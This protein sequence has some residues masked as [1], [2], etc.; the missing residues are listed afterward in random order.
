MDTRIAVVSIIVYDKESV[1]QINDILHEYNNIFLMK[2]N[3][4]SEN[5]FWKCFPENRYNLLI[6]MVCCFLSKKSKKINKKTYHV[7]I[8]IFWVNILIE[9]IQNRIYNCINKR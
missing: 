2:N 8:V 3:L 5:L 6:S 1:A 7:N 9:N 4:Y